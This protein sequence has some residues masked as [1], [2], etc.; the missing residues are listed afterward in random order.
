[1]VGRLGIVF[2]AM[3]IKGNKKRHL[4]DKEDNSRKRRGELREHGIVV[5]VVLWHVK[6][7]RFSISQLSPV[8]STRR[9][10]RRCEAL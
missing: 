7:H 3:Y 5:I 6:N 1:M 9:S 10:L 2:V 4:K 8:P